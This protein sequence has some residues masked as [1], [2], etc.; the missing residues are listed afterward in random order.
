MVVVV[1]VVALV[2][3]RRGREEGVWVWLVGGRL[4]DGGGL[5]VVWLRGHMVAVVVAV[6]VGGLVVYSILELK[7]DVVVWL[8]VGYLESELEFMVRSER[9]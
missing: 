1:V 2:I 3:G 4:S 9:C 5:G 6:V 7:G 8:W